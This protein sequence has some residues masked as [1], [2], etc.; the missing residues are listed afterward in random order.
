MNI[1][2][3]PHPALKSICPPFDFNDPIQ[4]PV[5]LGHKMHQVRTAARGA[6]LAAPQVGLL[7]RV[8]VMNSNGEALTCFNPEIVSKS[9][10][11]I[12]AEEGCLSFPGQ[13]L[14]IGRHREIVVAYQTSGGLWT[15]A[16][17]EDFPAV[18]FQ[19]E[20]DHLDGITFDTRA[21]MMAKALAMKEASKRAGRR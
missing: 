13:R 10:G 5:L 8:F 21:G 20:L 6:G 16:T 7:S 14:K 18:V 9:G 12:L 17:L 4:N 11:K 1:L 15:K 3:H 19:H 2:R